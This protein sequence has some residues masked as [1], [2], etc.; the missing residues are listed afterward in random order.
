MPYHVVTYN[1]M[2]YH[3]MPRHALL[4]HV[5]PSRSPCLRIRRHL[6]LL[7]C[8]TPD[9][10][11]ER[12]FCY[13]VVGQR[14]TEKE[15]FFTDTGSI[16]YRA[17]SCRPRPR[18]RGFHELARATAGH[19]T[20]E[21]VDGAAG[22]GGRGG[23]QSLLHGLDPSSL[24][25]RDCATSAAVSAARVRQTGAGPKARPRDACRDPGMSIVHTVVFTV[26][27]GALLVRKP[28]IV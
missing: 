15:C 7:A 20:R 25:P 28:L 6:G 5:T 13:C 10:G 4:Y 11:L 26:L 9:Q 27:V 21:W 2:S 8:K 18:D 19:R 16:P 17:M 24:L 12:S 23:R 3:V 22:A 14:L 1:T